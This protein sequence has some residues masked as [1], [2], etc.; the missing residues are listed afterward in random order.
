MPFVNLNGRY[1]SENVLQI[2][3]CTAFDKNIRHYFSEIF[4]IEYTHQTS[5]KLFSINCNT[6]RHEFITYIVYVLYLKL[7]SSNLMVQNTNDHCIELMSSR[8]DADGRRYIISLFYCA[9]S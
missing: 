7:C 3:I 9:K 5:S 1:E 6:Y 4:I 2:N 8:P